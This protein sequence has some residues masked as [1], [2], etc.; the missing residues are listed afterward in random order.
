MNVL[1]KRTFFFIQGIL[2]KTDSTQKFLRDNLAKKHQEK[3]SRKNLKKS[4]RK[5]PG[6]KPVQDKV[7]FLVPGG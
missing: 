4:L 2:T 5:S 3:N 7:A 6:E 1:L